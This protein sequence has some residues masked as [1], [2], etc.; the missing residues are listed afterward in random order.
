MALIGITIGITFSLSMILAPMLE[1]IIGVP[2]IFAMTGLLA[3]SAIAV[4]QWVIPRPTVEAHAKVSVAQFAQVLRHPELLRL[5]WGIFVLHALLMGIFVVVPQALV[6]AGL[7]QVDHWKLYLPVMA[8]SFVLMIPAVAIAHGQWRKTVF[9][10]SVAVLLLATGL[11]W[12]GLGSVMGIATALTV[13][14]VAFNVLE[15]SLPSLVTTVAPAEAKGTASGVYS[16]IQ[17]LGAFAGATLA[18]IISKYW[19]PDSVPVFC[20]SITALWLVVAWPM[21]VNK[22][23]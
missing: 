17:F 13:F 1:P 21:Q 2:G 15:A 16:S 9:L 4:V 6:K 11:L 18:G 3:L 14:F 8:G 22:A 19:G 7:L 12:L 20:A 5:N 23:S 10:A